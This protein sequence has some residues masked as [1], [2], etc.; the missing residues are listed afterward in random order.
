MNGGGVHDVSGFFWADHLIIRE[1]EWGE[2]GC[3][4]DDITWIINLYESRIWT[5]RIKTFVIASSDEGKGRDATYTAF[6]D[7]YPWF[8]ER[9]YAKEWLLF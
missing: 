8:W 9:K 7:L 2:W 4:K 6:S 3:E 1:G 5:I